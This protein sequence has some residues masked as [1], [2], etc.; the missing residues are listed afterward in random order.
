MSAASLDVCRF[1]CRARRLI[2]LLCFPGRRLQFGDLR[3]RRVG[4]RCVAG[5][6]CAI[7]LWTIAF[8]AASAFS[9]LD[10]FLAPGLGLGLYLGDGLGGGGHLLAVSRPFSHLRLSLSGG[11]PACTRS[12]ADPRTGCSALFFGSRPAAT[13]SSGAKGRDRTWPPDAP[14]AGPEILCAAVALRAG[15]LH[16][17]VSLAISASTE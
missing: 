14:V 7:S 13:R 15:V 5:P 1:R 10:R 6:L 11:P 8:C 9:R 2:A 3:A 12:S 16:V 4:A 17:P